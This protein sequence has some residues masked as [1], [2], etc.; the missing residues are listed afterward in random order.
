MPLSPESVLHHTPGAVLEELDGEA[1]IFHP[2]QEGFAVGSASTAVVWG[3]LDGERTVREVTQLLVD[4]YPDAAAVIP[5][6][7]T[8]ALEELVAHGLL[9]EPA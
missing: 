9:S 4:A 7:V 5:E 6:Q 2:S 3:L 1:M 8:T